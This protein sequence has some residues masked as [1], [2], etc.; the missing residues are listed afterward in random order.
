MFNNPS[1]MLKSGRKTRL[2]ISLVQKER[3]RK[4]KETLDKKKRKVAAPGDQPKKKAES[5]DS[6]KNLSASK[7]PKHIVPGARRS[8]RAHRAYRS[9]MPPT[10]QNDTKIASNDNHNE[11]TEQSTKIEKVENESDATPSNGKQNDGVQRSDLIKTVQKF[12]IF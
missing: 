9:D 12:Q 3:N 10:S 1:P 6:S 8:A 11:I 7:T 4:R 2:Q 5:S